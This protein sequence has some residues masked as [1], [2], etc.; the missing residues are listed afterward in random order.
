MKTK[1]FF[2]GLLIIAFL[3]TCVKLEQICAD[4]VETPL[5]VNFKTRQILKNRSGGDSIVVK[6]TFVYVKDIRIK[7][8]N[9]IVYEASKTTDSIT[10]TKLKYN[11]LKD[12]ITYAFSYNKNPT[13]QKDTFAFSYTRKIALSSPECGVRTDYANL[14]VKTSLISPTLKTTNQTTTV[15][16]YF[17]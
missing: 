1:L 17:K 11:P 16:V 9:T 12:S 6:D 4:A 5:T 10:T 14:Q 7:E 15:D 3:S 13:N 8:N 2:C